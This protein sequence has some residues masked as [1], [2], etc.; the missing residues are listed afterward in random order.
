MLRIITNTYFDG[1]EKYPSTISIIPTEFRDKCLDKKLDDSI[2]SI[3]ECL[4]KNKKVSLVIAPNILHL[5][6]NY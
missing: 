4:I 6:N 5:L 3:M 1:D 2:T